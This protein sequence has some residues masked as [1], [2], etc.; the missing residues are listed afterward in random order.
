MNLSL[1]LPQ[2]SAQ[3]RK[4]PGAVLVLFCSPPSH[5]KPHVLEEEK[6]L[7]WLSQTSLPSYTATRV[8]SVCSLVVSKTLYTSSIAESPAYWKGAKGSQVV[9]PPP[10]TLYPTKERDSTCFKDARKGNANQHI[11]P[12]HLQLLNA[13][14][15]LWKKHPLPAEG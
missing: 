4:K 15:F 14:V 5:P 1:P 8:V 12:R 10:R 13:A 3:R 2:L 11:L 7:P 9:T 6:Q